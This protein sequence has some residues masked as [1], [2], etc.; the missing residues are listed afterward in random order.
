MSPRCRVL[1]LLLPGESLLDGPVCLG[2]QTKSPVPLKIYFYHK[3]EDRKSTFGVLPPPSPVIHFPSCFYFPSF[4]FLFPNERTSRTALN[5]PIG[6]FWTLATFAWCTGTVALQHGCR[7]GTGCLLG[8]TTK[9][10]GYD[11]VMRLA[12]KTQENSGFR[13]GTR[14]D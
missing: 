2:C 1:P 4:S 11:A 10:L 14:T 8:F 6:R 5:V 9:V 13:A 12:I 3:T 7:K